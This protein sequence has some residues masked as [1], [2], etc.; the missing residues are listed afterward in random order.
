MSKGGDIVDGSG[1]GMF[2]GEALSPGAGSFSS[3]ISPRTSPVGGGPWG[4]GPVGG[5]PWGPGLGRIGRST[6]GRKLSD[7]KED[8][9]KVR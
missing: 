3:G 7:V 5:G 6:S 9:V 2:T 8:S 4:P 1:R